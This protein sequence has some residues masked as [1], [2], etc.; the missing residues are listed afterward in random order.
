MGFQEHAAAL[1]V[2]SYN[3][4]AGRFEF[5]VVKD[6]KAGS[7]PSITYANRYVC[8]NCHQNQAPLFPRQLWDET[9]ANPRV[10][11]L[12][13]AY[14]SEFQGV[15][16]EQDADV[17]YRIDKAVHRANQIA[18]YQRIWQEGLSNGGD[19]EASV[20]LR[21]AWLR[22]MLQFRISDSRNY[23]RQSPQFLRDFKKPL[24][25]SLKARFPRG[26]AIPNPEIPNRNPLAVLSREAS[27]DDRA[28]QHFPLGAAATYR[29]AVRARQS[30][31]SARDLE[32]GRSGIF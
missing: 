23:D 32:S 24:A 22:S 25:E 5:Q 13:K 18:V 31:S 12:L 7:T 3:E 29:G 27:M 1:E 14:A 9:N 26:I 28:V 20:H 2:I 30:A 4:Q 17:P 8:T 10:S 16:A 11:H 21:A 19:D 6:Y 15:P